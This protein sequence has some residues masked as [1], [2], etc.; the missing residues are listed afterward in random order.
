M[1]NLRF[2]GIAISLAILLICGF[3]M[4]K[5][6]LWGWWTFGFLSAFW[7][8][9]VF[10]RFKKYNTRWLAL[11]S[12]S[13]L[14]LSLGFPNSP[15]TLFMFVGFVPLLFI[16]KEISESK[17]REGV[18]KYAFNTFIIWNI[19]TTWWVAN[20]VLAGG[21]IANYL[22]AFFMCIPF[23]LFQKTDA[24]INPNWALQNGILQRVKAD[25]IL[26]YGAFIVYWLA[27]EYVHLNWEI[28]WTWLTLGNAFAEHPSWIQWYEFTGV[29]GG[30]LWILLLNVLIF[31]V[32]DKKYFKH[33][34]IKTSVIQC[35]AWLITPL[36]IS[37]LLGVE[38][39]DALAEKINVVAVQ[40]N[41]EPIYEKFDIPEQVQIKKFLK[42]ASEKVD[43]TTDYLVFPET[44]FDFRHV[45]R[46][47]ENPLVQELKDFTNRYPKLHLVTG[48]DAIKIYAP[49]V[50]EKPAGLPSTVREH[51]N[52][53]GTFTYWE[54]YNASTQL[55][56]G[57]DSLPIYVKSKFVPGPEILPY[58]FL[59]SWLKPVFKKFGGT[60]GGLGTQA[61]RSVFWNKDGKTAV[62]AMICYESIYGDYCTGF[63]KNGADALFVVSNDGWWGDTPGYEQLKKFACLRAIETR[64]PVVRSANTGSSCFIDIYGNISD[65]TPYGIDACIKGTIETSKKVTFFTLTGDLIGRVGKNL[66]IV[67]LIFLLLRVTAF[68]NYGKNKEK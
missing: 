6:L 57:I 20:A 31:R 27:F 5:L 25:E 68:R 10:L 38:K 48:I 47:N 21:L 61:E 67:F 18:M 59:F 16:Q 22:N 29:F 2:I 35:L 3:T 7:T 13:G 17:S 45:D 60:V 8:L 65:A 53:D 40:P 24:A 30:S 58:G 46:W 33:E 34:P 36:S 42:L 52:N 62:G 15:F 19:L 41:Y 9:I 66:A 37:L 32:I 64:R 12:L 55:A 1:K 49:Y 54:N 56:A 4:S 26:K 39:P 63:V 50:R 23:W 44:S 51:D 43:S 11:S 14:F 28:S